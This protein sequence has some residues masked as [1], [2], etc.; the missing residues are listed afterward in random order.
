MFQLAS[1]ILFF[2]A[3]LRLAAI[4]AAAGAALFGAYVLIY[5]SV[6]VGLGWIVGAAGIGWVVNMLLVLVHLLG[7]DAATSPIRSPVRK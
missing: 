3:L 6:L 7:S 2:V 1:R 5:E 4:A